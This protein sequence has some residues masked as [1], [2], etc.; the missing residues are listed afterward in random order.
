MIMFL[1]FIYHTLGLNSGQLYS[2][3]LQAA[4]EGIWNSEQISW[5]VGQPSHA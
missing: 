2:E 5:S 4:E 3:H 1:C